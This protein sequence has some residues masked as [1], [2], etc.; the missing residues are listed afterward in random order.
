MTDEKDVILADEE[1]ELLHMPW[2]G[3]SWARAYIDDNHVGSP[4]ERADALLHPG[5]I[6]Y[7]EKSGARSCQL[8]QIPRVEGAIVSLNPN[9]GSI[10]ALSGG[11]DFYQSKFNRAIQ[12]TRQPGS[13]FKPFIYSAALDKGFTAA[14]IIN[15]AP[16]VFD[17]PGLESTWRPENY[18]GR[19][20]GPTRLRVAL[21]HS[22]NLVSIRLLRSIGINYTLDYLGRFGFDTAHLPH[23]LSLALGSGA[24]TPLQLAGGYA[25]F[26]NGGYRVEPYLAEQI[27][28]DSETVLKANPP[29][30]CSD[31][32]ISPPQEA[33]PTSDNEPALDDDR[34]KPF[35]PRR[36]RINRRRN[37]WP[38][39]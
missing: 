26:A 23:D 29:I 21:I 1:S 8:A 25:V 22:R 18:S 34:V 27:T 3:L 7:V 37:G 32:E 28:L 36:Q 30:V 33:T 16:V 12:A 20:F 39:A 14:S 15:D 35:R 38:N 11:F 6:V 17:D 5:D 31:C 19:F 2:S 9:D 13:S 24:I 4:V 10:I